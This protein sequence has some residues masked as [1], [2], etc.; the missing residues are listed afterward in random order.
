M[1]DIPLAVFIATILGGIIVY[2]YSAWR[3]EKKAKKFFAKYKI[4]DIVKMLQEIKE[5]LT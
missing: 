4:E 3:T 2:E 5:A 1:L